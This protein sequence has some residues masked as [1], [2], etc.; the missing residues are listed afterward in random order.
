LSVGF[1][2][3]QLFEG[4]YELGFETSHFRPF[5][6]GGW[7]ISTKEPSSW[8]KSDEEAEAPIAPVSVIGDRD[9]AFIVQFYGWRTVGEGRFGHLGGAS[10]EIVVD[11]FVSVCKFG[12]EERMED[13][14]S[15]KNLNLK[16]CLKSW[17]GPPPKRVDL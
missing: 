11:K 8:L 15:K 3:R 9:G 2:P 4:F 12:R 10:S 16:K 6:R 7:T 14:L 13:G 1:G 5:E 17:V